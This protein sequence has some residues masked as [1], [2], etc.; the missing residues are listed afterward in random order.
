M[1]SGVRKGSVQDKVDCIFGNGRQ[2]GDLQDWQVT[3]IKKAITAGYHAGSK[4][5]PTQRARDGAKAAAYDALRKHHNEF[6]PCGS[7]L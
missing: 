6:C 5:R 4:Q 3:A 1:K 7:L 2:F